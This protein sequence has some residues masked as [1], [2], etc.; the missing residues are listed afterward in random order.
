M[1]K[2]TFSDVKWH[3]SKLLQHANFKDCHTFFY[4]KRLEQEINLQC[5]IV[6][7][8]NALRH[9]KNLIIEGKI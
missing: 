3:L 4:N 2:G 5:H 9:M 6:K 8:E 1:K 7:I